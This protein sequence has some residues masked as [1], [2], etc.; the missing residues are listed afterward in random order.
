VALRAAVVAPAVP[1]Y[2]ALLCGDNTWGQI[3]NGSLTTPQ[4][5]RSQLATVSTAAATWKAIAA[6][7][8]HTLAI[9]SDG[10]LWAWGLNLNGQLGNGESGNGKYRAS[11]VQIGTAKDWLEVA[12]GDSHSLA[13]SGTATTQSLWSWGQNT[14]GQLGLGNLINKS[15]P[16]KITL[17][18]IWKSI[19]AGGSFCLALRNTDGVVYSWGDDSSGQ[20]GQ[21]ASATPT[22][23][24]ATLGTGI[25]AIA[26]AAGSSHA[27]AIQDDRTLVA[28]GLNAS[29]QLGLGNLNNSLAPVKVGTDTNWFAIAAGGNHTLAIKLDRTLWSWGSNSDG[30][31][32]EGSTTQSTVPKQV[33]TGTDWVSVAAGRSHSM[34]IDTSG[35]LYVWGR[36]A[37]GQ[38]GNGGTTGPV[39]TPTLVP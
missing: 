34:A 23:P 11:P 39:L 24:T 33:G 21:L 35:R 9:K 5:T 15:I 8:F 30:Q 31:L 19:A 7:E 20:L 3:G 17:T 14:V 6:G 2:T 10:T 13:R 18:G 22:V 29:G 27:L 38:L 25:P 32:G 26:I 1:T 16:T 12:A 37:E 28:W 4:T 36:N